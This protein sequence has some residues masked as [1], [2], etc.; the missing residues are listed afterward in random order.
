LA[1]LGTCHTK[2]SA[3]VWRSVSYPRMRRK[4]IF[5]SVGPEKW[6]EAEKL[7]SSE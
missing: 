3:A 2:T 6:L 4:G 1:Q 5:E 7:T